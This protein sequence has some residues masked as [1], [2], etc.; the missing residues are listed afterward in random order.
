[1]FQVLDQIK[2]AALGKGRVSFISGKFNVL[3][4]GHIRLFRFAR[5]VSDFLIVGIYPDGYVEDIIFSER[6]RLEGVSANHWVD[7]AFV[8]KNS[9]ESIIAQIR[10]DVVVKGKEHEGSMNPEAGVINEYGGTLRFVSGD[11]RFSDHALLRS[12]INDNVVSHAH[13]YL[14]RRKI[15]RQRLITLAEEFSTIRTLVIGDL[16]VDKYVE[17]EPVGMSSESPT[18][19]VRPVIEKEFVGGAGIVAA[20]A[21]SLGGQT[22]FISVCGDD[23]DGR[24]GKSV[25]EQY[26]VQSSISND[27][28]RSTTIKTRYRAQ[29]QTLFRVNQFRDHEIDKALQASLYAKALACLD[30]I[31]LLILSDFGYGLLSQELVDSIIVA[32]NERQIIIAAD[33]QSSSQLGNIGR[34][35]GTSLITPTEKEARLATQNRYAGLVGITEELTKITDATQIILT[36]GSE[37]VFVHSGLDKKNSE[38]DRI[39]ALNRRPTDVA[40]AGDAFLVVA[41]LGISVGAN[42]WE[43]AYLGSMAAGCQVGRIGNVPL[44]KTELFAALP[45]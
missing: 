12:E 8:I 11:T 34:F 25:I 38:D 41:A 33:S 32:A 18:I 9:P 22:E 4:P 15:S 1:M 21:A 2:K 45:T 19:V 13:E 20:H 27:V 31:D 30:R 23:Q 7:F 5:E 24:Y 6:E 36:L 39:P 16:I 29:G 17:C 37:G 14:S 35:K 28:D 44:Q 40:G 42:I 10:P 3:H 26:N 43:A